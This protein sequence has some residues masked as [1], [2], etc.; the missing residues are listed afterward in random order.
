LRA[1]WQLKTLGEICDIARGGS[2]RPIQKYLTKEADGV[3]WI[4]IGDATASD[5]YIYKTE[6]KIKPDGIKRSRLVQEGDF[7]LSNSMSFGRPYIMKTTGCIHDGWLVLSDK[8]KLFNQDYLYHFLGSAAAYNQFDKLAAGSTVR[9]L[10]IDLVKRV[11]VP[12]PPLPEQQR[13]VAILDET[14]S[15]LATVVNNTQKNLKNAKELFDNSL[16]VFFPVLSE[17][18]Y[19][20]RNSEWQRVCIRDVCDSIVDCPNRTAPKLD[21]PSPYKM[22][23]TTNV[24]HGRINLDDVN[25]VSEEVYRR[26]TRRQVPRRGDVILTR[27]APLGEVGILDTDDSVFLGQRLVSYRVTPSKLISEFLFFSLMSRDL[28]DQIK[29][30]GSGATV[31]HMRVPDSKALMLSIPSLSTQQGI[32]DKLKEL[33]KASDQLIANYEAKLVM[34]AQ[35]KQ[36]I[37]H[38]AFSGKLTPTA[39]KEAAE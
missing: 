5:K 27:E 1:E 24:R 36:S 19:S 3:N 14:F 38:T 9:N 28:K 7:L 31:Q 16:N 35:L 4:K 30:F 23:R 32:V 26:W 12:L 11:E 25:F 20:R 18:G 10:N 33:R 17:P 15:Q 39:I 8:S 22:I 34:A 29:R 37:L 13:I 21:K 2:P 6:E